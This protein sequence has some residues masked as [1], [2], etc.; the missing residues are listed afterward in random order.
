MYFLHKSIWPIDRILIGT[1]TPEKSGPGV[2][3]MKENSIVPIA[4]DLETRYQF[5][6]IQKYF[7]WGGSYPSP[8][9]AVAYPNPHPTK[10]RL[11]Y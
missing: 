6:V 9:D 3:A 1:I 4:P 10:T 8:R 5:S 11:N 2:M 7:I